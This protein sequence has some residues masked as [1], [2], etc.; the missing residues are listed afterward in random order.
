[1]RT[2]EPRAGNAGAL[3]YN[4]W[5]FPSRTW[6]RLHHTVNYQ[7][8]TPEEPAFAARGG[9]VPGFYVLIYEDLCLANTSFNL[10]HYLDL[11]KDR[12]RRFAADRIFG[13]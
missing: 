3:G 10:E 4:G 9:C 8:A 5:G 12:S 13:S 11:Y 6:F 7:A 1:M 2:L